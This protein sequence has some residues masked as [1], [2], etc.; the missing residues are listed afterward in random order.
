M[1]PPPCSPVMDDEFDQTDLPLSKTLL[2]KNGC[3]QRGLNERL[4][5]L[6]QTRQIL[7]N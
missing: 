6:T 1:A 7:G 5:Q 2:L 3:L 4:L